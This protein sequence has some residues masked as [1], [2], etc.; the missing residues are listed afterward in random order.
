MLLS[1]WLV[2]MMWR[3]KNKK[4][5]EPICASHTMYIYFNMCEWGRVGG[6]TG[7]QLTYLVHSA[8]MLLQAAQYQASPFLSFRNETACVDC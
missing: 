4:I 7:T 5:K 1:I 2:C 8:C 6:R 3:V